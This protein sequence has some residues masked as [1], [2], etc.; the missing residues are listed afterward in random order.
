[1]ENNLDLNENEVDYYEEMVNDLAS[2]LEECTID[3]QTLQEQ[4]DT[5]RQEVASYADS[6]SAFE[7]K[8]EES[9]TV[10]ISLSQTLAKKEQ[11]NYEL[12][13]VNF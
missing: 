9:E 7:R 4:C 13:K 11:S 2:R 8:L 5:L 12:Q 1:M 10:R 3:K 6:V